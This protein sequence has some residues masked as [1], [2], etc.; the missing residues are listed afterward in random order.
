MRNSDGISVYYD[1]KGDGTKANINYE[2]TDSRFTQ[3]LKRISN[4]SEGL[5]TLLR[6]SSRGKVAP[7]LLAYEKIYP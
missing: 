5:L 7:V 6:F 4:K 3:R 1:D 2:I